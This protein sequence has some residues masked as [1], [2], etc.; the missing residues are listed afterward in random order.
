VLGFSASLDLPQVDPF[1]PRF[2][3]YDDAWLA[4]L[5]GTG[6]ALKLSSYLGGSG[7]EFGY[8]LA[9]A[10]GTAALAGV[11]A[12][13]DFPVT[14]SAPQPGYGGGVGDAF[15]SLVDLG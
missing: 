11:T 14:P 15:V 6:R 12:S 4:E 8:G 5:T 10:G 3:G 9:L 13:T 7:Q 1:Q 2:G